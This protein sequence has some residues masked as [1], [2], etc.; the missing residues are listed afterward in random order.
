MASSILLLEQDA[1]LASELQGGL[2]RLGYEVTALRD[3]RTGLA[4]AVSQRF[5]VIVVSAELPGMNGFRVCNRIKK[6]ANAQRIPLILIG[7]VLSEL[8]AHRKLPTRAQSYL[9]RPIRLDEVVVS[10][11]KLLE[12][13]VEAN[14]TIADP[15]E[16]EPAPISQP[17]YVEDPASVAARE[18]LVKELAAAQQR[19]STLEDLR[20]RVTEHEKTTQRL[21]KELAEARAQLTKDEAQK[22]EL[23]KLRTTVADT[24]NKW[25]GE[26][27]ALAEAKKKIE[28]LTNEAEATKADH[29][30]R[31]A[32]IEQAL[33]A[34]DDEKMAVNKRAEGLARELDELRQKSNEERQALMRT[35]RDEIRADHE[36]QISALKTENEWEV[37]ALG[38]LLDQERAEAKHVRTANEDALRTAQAEY[39]GAIEAL[40]NAL[41]NEQQLR[42]V[43]VDK[44]KRTQTKL[45]EIESALGAVR[46]KR[47]ELEETHKATVRELAA[48]YEVKRAALE[49]KLA[50][51]SGT[52]STQDEAVSQLRNR[53][54]AELAAA[55]L[56]QTG[57]M[58]NLERRVEEL[59]AQ[60]ATTREN[61]DHER[62][63]RLV[64]EAE[65]QDRFD[66]LE[67]A[68]AAKNTEIER[69]GHELEVARAEVPQLEAEIVVLRSELVNLRRQADQE[70]VAAQVA[71]DQLSKNRVL[72]DRAKQ[73]LEGVDSRDDSKE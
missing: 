26:K 33:A 15:V 42:A 21:T 65:T 20:R 57:R 28:A 50:Q 23:A 9:E 44:V 27:R 35:L 8:D 34:A 67:S 51:V 39:K 49:A 7:G 59:T 25:E 62:R 31:V 58:A 6:D 30:T 64:E 46:R 61:L 69:L 17:I 3:G 24:K 40:E 36:A 1:N 32:S 41:A 2:R 38:A 37:S 13:R 5:D 16:I 54:G 47:T 72:L 4:R 73:A 19:L 70:A 12:E 43:E 63:D 56:E 53:H 14:V 60:L 55:R 45:A 66:A 11:R 68:V 22:V 48:K 52:Q 71:T 18:R 10:V 29:A